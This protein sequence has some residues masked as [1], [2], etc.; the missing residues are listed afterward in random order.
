M[1]SNSCKKC[2][3]KFDAVELQEPNGT[4]MCDDCYYGG[5]GDLVEEQMRLVSKKKQKP[6]KVKCQYCQD[7][8]WVWR[9][10]YIA[11][12]CSEYDPTMPCPQ[13]KQKPV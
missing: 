6:K 5:L 8:G 3:R 4:G 9:P 1:R 2:H 11:C 13:C 12:I 10:F 7:K